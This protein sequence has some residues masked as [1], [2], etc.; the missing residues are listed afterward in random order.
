MLG[1][2]AWSFCTSRWDA[3][4]TSYFYSKSKLH[5]NIL[6]QRN[7]HSFDHILI[8]SSLGDRADLDIKSSEE[9]QDKTIKYT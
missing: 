8:Y 5:A 4:I 1:H 3:C 2:K 9:E 6:F 7:Q